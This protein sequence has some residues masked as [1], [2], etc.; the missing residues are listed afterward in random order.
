[1]KVFW[2]T[3]VTSES[4]I[5]TKQGHVMHACQKSIIKIAFKCSARSF[6][7]NW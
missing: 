7:M 2:K 4:Q 3:K 6:K 1:M 5:A